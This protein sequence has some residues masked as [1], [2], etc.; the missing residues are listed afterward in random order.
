MKKILTFLS[1]ICLLGSGVLISSCNTKADDPETVVGKYHIP[2][3][4]ERKTPIGTPDETKSIRDTYDKGIAS[5]KA[6]GDDMKPLLSLASAFILEGRVTGN[7]GYY[8]NAAVKVLNQV[9]DGEL[10]SKDQRFQALSMKSAVLLNM[11]QFKDA[12]EVANEGVA[13]ND[14]NAGIYGALVDANVELGHYP[15]AVKACDQ[16]LSIRPDLR[17]YSRASYLRQIHGDNRGAIEAMKMAVEAG[18]PGAESTE[19]ARVTLG[20]LY[21]NIGN[22]DSASLLYRTSLVYRPDY[23][24]AN[25]G[26]A[27]AARARKDYDGAIGYTRAAIKTLS[28]S[29]FVSYLAD[30]YELKGDAAK[31]AQVRG[32]VLKLLEDARTSGPR[33]PVIPHNG[34][35]ELGTAYLNMKQYDKALEYARKDWESRPD[36]IDA[37]ELMAWI[38]YQKGDMAHAKEHAEKT[39]ITHI[40]NA[41]T[42]YKNGIILAAAGD[43]ARGNELKQQAL[44]I[45]PYIDQRLVGASHP[46]S[47]R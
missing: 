41:N 7:G 13:L 47:L 36:N 42:L 1:L 30:L 3:L 17:S 33:N 2:L 6:N 16:M 39:M 43:A 20:D 19:W 44:A 15:E 9:L 31:A 34:N 4:L 38:Y 45:S 25:M 10:A 23:P 22:G 29:S 40:A 35:R 12:L 8:S 26:M 46:L 11:H 21:L 37:N 18:V 27:R 14:F 5:L 32:D 28:E 24:F